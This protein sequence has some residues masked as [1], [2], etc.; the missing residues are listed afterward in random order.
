[1]RTNQTLPL[2][3]RTSQLALST[4][5]RDLFLAIDRPFAAWQKRRQFRQ[6]LRRMPDYLL[7]DIG[8]TEARALDEISKPFWRA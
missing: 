4:V 8:L 5:L 6:E 3:A 1:M 7:H 2:S